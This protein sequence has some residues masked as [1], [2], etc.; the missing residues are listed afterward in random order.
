MIKTRLTKAKNPLN[1]LLESNTLYGTL[2]SKTAVRRAGNKIKRELS[3]IEKVVT[4][5]QDDYALNEIE[6]AGTIIETLVK[7]AAEIMASVDEIVEN[8][9]YKKDFTRD[10]FAFK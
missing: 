4:S 2:P 6:D 8:A 5:L 9:M 10:S 1:E 7:E 3:L